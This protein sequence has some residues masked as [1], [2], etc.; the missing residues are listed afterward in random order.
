MFRSGASVQEQRTVPVFAAG[1]L[2]R[3]TRDRAGEGVSKAEGGGEGI[4]FIPSVPAECKG[5]ADYCESAREASLSPHRTP[6]QTLVWR[7][8]Q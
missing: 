8:R 7:E 5:S 2:G 1:P 4:L 3:Q 6:P